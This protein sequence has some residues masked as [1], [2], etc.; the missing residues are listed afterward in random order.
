MFKLKF[1]GSQVSQKLRAVAKQSPQLVDGALLDTAGETLID[2]EKTT[3]TW[4]T[5][6]KFRVVKIGKGYSVTTKS[7]IY[8][9]IDKG[10]RPYL[11]RAKYAPRLVFGVGGKPKT[12]ANYIGSTAGKP[13]TGIR[14]ALVVHH[15]GIKARNFTKLIIAKHQKRVVSNARKALKGGVEAIGL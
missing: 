13:S 8:K 7:D 14:S 11:I 15:P 12:R 10:T 1:V 4:K 2:F 3:A 5:K 9:F 6:P